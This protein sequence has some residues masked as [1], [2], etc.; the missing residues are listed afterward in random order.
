ML[1]SRTHFYLIFKSAPRIV[2]WVHTNRFYYTPVSIVTNA[3]RTYL[4]TVVVVAIA[5]VVIIIT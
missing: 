5:V 3:Y 2:C 4:S 1:L